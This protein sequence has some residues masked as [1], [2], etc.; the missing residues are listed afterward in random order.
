MASPARK[1]RSSSARSGSSL[2]WPSSARCNA[3]TISWRSCCASHRRSACTQKSSTPIRPAISAT[4]RRRSRTSRSSKRRPGSSC[5]KSSMS[6]EPTLARQS[7]ESSRFSGAQYEIVHAAQRAVIVEF[8]GGL[9][10][11]AV[12][13]RDVLDGY[14]RGEMCAAGRGQVLAPW[15][16]RLADGSYEFNGRRHQLPLTEPDAHNAIHGLVQWQPWRA[17]E[18]EARRVVVEHV[19][20]PQPGYPFALELRIEYA[21]SDDGLMVSM[22]ATNV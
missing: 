13:D 11:Y 4:S 18:Q 9:R 8:G 21:L 12:G 17:C 5:P 10:S 3:R 1:A 19:L 15:P 22:R 20:R 6:T 7:T 2:H 16:N 14:A